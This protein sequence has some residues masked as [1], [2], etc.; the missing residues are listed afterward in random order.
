MTQWAAEKLI[1]IN[2]RGARC[3][4]CGRR[5]ELLEFH[6]GLIRRNSAFSQYLDRRYNGALLC[7]VC[8]SSGV[9]DGWEWRCQFWLRQINRYGLTVMEDWLRGLPD[10][11]RHRIDFVS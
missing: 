5:T 10:K 4:Q 3:E 1:A 7:Q 6:H 8:H 11:L 2:E 9:V